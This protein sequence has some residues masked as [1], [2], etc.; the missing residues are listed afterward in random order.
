MGRH[1]IGGAL[2]TALSCY[3]AAAHAENATCPGG[4]VTVEY[5]DAVDARL[6]C[7]AARD[8]FGFF[9][10]LGMD[11]ELSLSVEVSDEAGSGRDGRAIGAY[12]REG[13]R[14]IVLSY[15]RCLELT[16]ET[17]PFGMDMNEDLH[18][19]FIAHEMAHAIV[20]ALQ[21]S[22]RSR[23]LHEYIAYVVQLDSLPAPMREGIVARYPVAPFGR[24]EEMD[25]T[26]YLLDPS[27]F[28]IKAYRHWRDS[29]D[30]V[31]FVRSLLAP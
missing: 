5:R 21:H 7:A 22:L 28:A 25:E 16:R 29:G 19:S 11:R 14:I 8:A 4:R 12:A 30:G 31:Q 3:A 20:H 10:R 2:I 13:S 6:A 24:V 9:E 18:R 23:V 1:V 27:S 26:Y 15:R 17:R